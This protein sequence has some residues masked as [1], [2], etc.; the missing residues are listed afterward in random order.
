MTHPHVRAAIAPAL[1][2]AYPATVAAALWPSTWAFAVTALIAYVADAL[3]VRENLAITER[4]AQASAGVTVRFLLREL[5][6]L[7]LL[8]RLGH[9][10]DTAYGVLAAGLLGLHALRGVYSGL[11]LY[12]I[13]RRRLPLVTRGLDVSELRIP[14][15]PNPLMTTR[16]TR[17]MLHLDVPVLAGALFGVWAGVGG[18]AVAY[19]L[20]LLALGVMG[21]HALRNRH[22]G[23]EDRI[24]DVVNRR[25]AELAPEAALYF[26]GTADAAYQANMWLATMDD[27]EHQAVI[28][29]RERVLVPLLGRS[30]TPILCAPKA[31]D[32]AR[33]DLSTVRS[34]LYPANVGKN[35]HMLRVSG[36]RSTSSSATATATSPPVST[37]TPRSM[38]RSGSP[39]RPDGSAT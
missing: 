14:D 17:T 19:A 35:L 38:T 11:T 30:R 22:L 37:R 21:R 18:L 34:A 2:L 7:L 1:L 28:I 13:R 36:I 29:L 9:A 6:L 32:M 26:S 3:A 33:L 23:D 25:L 16:H 12:V 39:V 31:M 4:L 20:G 15:A 24:L 8:A 5:A 10:S 27:L